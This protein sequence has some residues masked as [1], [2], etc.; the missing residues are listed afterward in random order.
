MKRSEINSIMRSAD[1]F[2]RE[3]GFSLPPFAYWTPDN[4]RQ[5]GLEVREIVKNHLGWDITDFG[6]GN[7][8]DCG[9]FLFTLRNGSS[10]N[11]R[12][13]RGK[14]YAEKL[15]V[16]DVDQVTPMHFHWKK[17]EDIINRAGGNLMVQ[18]FLSTE[19]EKI[20]LE[21]E[22]VVSVDSVERKL[23]PGGMVTLTPGQS[24]T[25]P[26]FCYHKFW[27]VEKRVLV[28]EVSMVNDDSSDN[29]F[30]DQRGRFPVIDE[31]EPPLYLLVTDYQQYY[32]DFYEI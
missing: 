23:P 19:D 22:L 13:L 6:S 20:D 16:V 30:I 11:W 8:Q 32:R 15:L 2:I 3:S 25:L 10:D 9:L 4:W 17:M 27:G 26:P 18:L 7:F 29:R 21:R 12:D 1:M 24:I 28:G 31:D 14:L 5:K